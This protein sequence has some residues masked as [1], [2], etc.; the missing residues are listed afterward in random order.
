MSGERRLTARAWDG[1]VM[2]TFLG[3]KIMLTPAQARAFDLQ[4]SSAAGR[5]SAYNPEVP[6]WHA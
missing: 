1:L 6:A 3:M 5:A 4:L 2:V